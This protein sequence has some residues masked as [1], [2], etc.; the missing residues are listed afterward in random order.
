MKKIVSQNNLEEPIKK[1]KTKHI[2]PLNV[3]PS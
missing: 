2:N 3:L 1:G